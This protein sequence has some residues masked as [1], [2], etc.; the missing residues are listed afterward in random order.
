V[1]VVERAPGALGAVVP[2]AVRYRRLVV[3]RAD[4]CVAADLHPAFTAIV[5][6]PSA[7]AEVARLAAG[8]IDGD[9]PGVHLEYVDGE[10]RELLAFRPHGGRSRLVDLID[11]VEVTPVHPAP[12]AGEADVL[13]LL[14]GVSPDRLVDVV[15]RLFSAVEADNFREAV[16]RERSGRRARRTRRADRDAESSTLG[17]ALRAWEVM[18]PGVSGT[19]AVDNAA[20]VGACAEAARRAGALAAVEHGP[21][22]PARVVAAVAGLVG[23]PAWRPQ[24]VALPRPDLGAAETELLL[25][26]LPEV[27]RGRQVIVVTDSSRVASWT[28]LEALAGRASVV[29]ADLAIGS[30]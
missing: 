27:M 21:L 19:W 16:R 17:S 10:G 14:A 15:D 9:E 1:V 25:D 12:V 5:V 29:E 28:R 26:L 22:E 2:G 13:R 11:A 23:A 6:R 4:Q 24:V 8:A 7:V 3:D 18:L 30:I 20:A